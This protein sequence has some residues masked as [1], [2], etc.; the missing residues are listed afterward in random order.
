MAS[1]VAQMVKTLPAMQET[2]VQSLAWDDPL[3]K[4][5]ETHSSILAWR[6]SWTEE[7]G[8]LQS[9]VLQRIRQ[10]W[11]TNSFTFT[12]VDV[13]PKLQVNNIVIHSFFFFSFIFISWR[14][15]TLQYCSGFCHTLTWISHG[16]TCIPHSD[17]P[18]HLPLY[19]LKVTLHL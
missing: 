19:F 9:M 12:I 2:W 6:I 18:S 3:E 13:Q 14:L 5:I 8:G 11:A 15:I 4:E 7:S 17:P 10:N 16:V 1:L